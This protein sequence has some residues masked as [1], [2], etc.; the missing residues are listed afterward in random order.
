MGGGESQVS[1]TNPKVVLATVRWGDGPASG[2]GQRA[3]HLPDPQGRWTS[4]SLVLKVGGS[5]DRATDAPS[6][7][8]IWKYTFILAFK[9]KHS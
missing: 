4:V 8:L 2:C 9:Q 3:G 7:A 1:S 5:P 6:P